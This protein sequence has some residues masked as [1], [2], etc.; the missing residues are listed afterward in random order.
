MRKL[1]LLA[2]VGAFLFSCGGSNAKVTYTPQ[3]IQEIQKTYYKKGYELGY[4]MG[5]RVGYKSAITTINRNIEKWKRDILALEVGKFAV[6]KG[7]IPAPKTYRQIINGQPQ[8]IIEGEEITPDSLDKLIFF[9]I[10]QPYSSDNAEKF[11]IPEV[12]KEKLIG[13]NSIQKVSFLNG[14]NNGVEEGI[15]KGIKTAIKDAEKSLK[16]SLVEKKVY[17]LELDKYIN[18]SLTVTAPRIYRILDGNVVKY[19]IIPSR[20]E[21]IRTIDDIINGNKIPSPEMSLKLGNA[22]SG[23][24][25][26]ASSSPLVL[27]SKKLH[28]PIRVVIPCDKLRLLEKLGIDYEIADNNSCRAVFYDRGQKES[29]CKEYGFCKEAK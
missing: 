5:F 10:P 8:I 24:T 15:D 13:L 26:P 1:L 19:L 12:P 4:E 9:Y 2:T 14:F 27:P 25:L 6:K 21:S 29:F 22:G 11:T 7:I 28:L 16:D 23:I 20:V 3:Q 18:E 17:T